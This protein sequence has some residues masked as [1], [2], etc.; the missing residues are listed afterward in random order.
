MEE[1]MPKKRGIVIA[2]PFAFLPDN[3]PKVIGDPSPADVRKYL[4]YWDEIDYPENDSIHFATGP[5][6]QFL[7]DAKAA[8]RSL[9]V[10]KR[11]I[12]AKFH[13]FFLL[14]QQ[15][16]FEK[17]EKESP[18]LW[19]LAQLSTTPHFIGSNPAAVSVEYELW[20]MLP[21]PTRDV[22]LNDIL[23]FKTKRHDELVALQIHLN[24]MY[25]SIICSV[26]LPRAKNT[27]LAKLEMDL[28]AIDRTLSESKIRKS[29]T[30]LRDFITGDF[31]NF[32]GVGVT[33]VA[34]SI[35][36]SLVTAGIVGAGVTFA[37][38]LVRSP[39]VPKDAHP[40]TYVSSIR[41]EL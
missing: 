2:P 3:E 17:Y 4:L 11:P 12:S 30:S 5:D 34:T 10:L 23:E 6:L 1:S 33:G 22:P 39:K 20:N 28:K 14:T 38:R 37:L 31:A 9:V 35:G 29:V 40:L 41:K 16:V 26:D 18:G 32:A 8:K 15:I 21:V 25:Q 7:I 24:E 13:E 36:M 27:Q 19:S